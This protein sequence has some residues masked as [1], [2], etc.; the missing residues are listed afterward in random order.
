MPLGSA[1]LKTDAESSA[2]A[3]LLSVRLL[4]EEVRLQGKGAAQQLLVI[5]TYA[6]GLERDLTGESRFSLAHPALAAI[7]ARG[8][9]S[10]R[11]DGRTLL[12]VQSSGQVLQAAVQV[13]DSAVSAPLRFDRDIARILTRRGCNSTECHG[14]VT[15]QGGFKL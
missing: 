2:A 1:E 10:A 15:G 4:P 11:S 5:G 3:R 7:D 14:S 8:R 13:R 6:D 12:T 9:V